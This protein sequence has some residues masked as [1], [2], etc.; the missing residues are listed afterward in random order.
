MRPCPSSTTQP[1]LNEA[2][3]IL[4]RELGLEGNLTSIVHKAADQLGVERGPPL[5]ELGRQC[6]RA[7]KGNMQT[8]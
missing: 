7:L 5:A 6:L 4:K 1:T 2:A 3:E 8:V